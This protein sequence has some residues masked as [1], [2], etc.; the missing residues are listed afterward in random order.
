M[1]QEL[2]FASYP[3]F[4]VRG[5]SLRDLDRDLAAKEVVALFDD[6]SDR[7]TVRGMYTTGGFTASG[8]R[9]QV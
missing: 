8:G 6:F 7:V 1:T 3:V 4:K 9:D 5:H 2:M